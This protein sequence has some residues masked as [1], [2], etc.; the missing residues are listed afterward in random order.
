MQNR[1]AQYNRI[2]Y[3]GDASLFDRVNYRIFT[4]FMEEKELQTTMMQLIKDRIVRKS[5]GSKTSDTPDFVSLIDQS[6][7]DGEQT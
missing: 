5:S 6:I 1:I 7:K 2:L 3:T 4:R